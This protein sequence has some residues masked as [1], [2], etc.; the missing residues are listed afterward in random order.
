MLCS[1]KTQTQV[2]SRQMKDTKN[3]PKKTNKQ[4]PQPL[5]LSKFIPL[6]LANNAYIQVSGSHSFSHSVKDQSTW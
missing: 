5:L 3:H 1:K 6:Y 4:K 2:Q